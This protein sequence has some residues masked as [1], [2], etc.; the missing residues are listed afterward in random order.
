MATTTVNNFVRS[1]D[2]A[3][4]IVI[5]LTVAAGVINAGDMLYLTAAKGAASL[6]TAGASNANAAS[7]IGVSVDT[8][9][10]VI[11]DGVT[12]G[13]PSNQGPARVQYRRKGQFRFH[14]T[15]AETYH[16]GDLVYL[17]ADGQTISTVATGTSVGKVSSDQR[18]VGGVLGT[19]ITGAAGQ[20][21]IISITP[22]VT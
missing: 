2:A 3:L 14:T 5:D 11:T 18:P 22:I 20:D 13:F 9:P 12:A 6:T 8:Y 7:F 10:I 21:V 15:A 19:N 4:A 16:V 17:G 1:D